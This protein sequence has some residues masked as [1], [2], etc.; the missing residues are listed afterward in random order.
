MSVKT[1]TGPPAP[2]VLAIVC[3]GV[4][5]TALD[6][7]VVVTALP[8]VMVDIKVPISEI[9]QAS[10]IVTG[11][12]VGYTIAMPLVGRISDVY[13]H[14]RVYQ[15]AL[16]L[17]SV[18]SLLVAVADD[19]PWMIS[20][21]VIQAI[22]GGATVPISMAIASMAMPPGRRGLA[23]GLVG[24]SAEAGAMLG[25]LYGGGIIE[26]LEWRWI[27]WLDI[28]QSAVLIA[29]FGLLYNKR[30]PGARVDYLGGALL[31]G[32]L[33]VLTVAL[34]RREM[35]ALEEAASSGL[36][37]LLVAVGL[38]AVVVLVLVEMRAW[39]PLL[40]PALFRSAS[41]VTSNA[42]QL[43]V[44]VALIMA[45][46]NVPLMANTVMGKDALDG[47]LQLMRLT[48]AIPVGAVVGGYVL[49]R[50]GIRRVTVAGLVLMA[51]G[52]YFM[53]TWEA[54]VGEPWL[55]LHLVT[56]GLGFGLVIAPI[57]TTAMSA[58][59]PDYWATAASLVTVSRMVGMALGLAALSAW[60]TDHFLGLT[61][62]LEVPIGLP[63]ES[64]A[65]LAAR[66]AEY[67]QG[68]T[69]AG[70]TLF[71]DFFRVSA[72]ISVVAIL[73]ALG[74]KLA[75]RRLRDMASADDP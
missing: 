6:Q 61:A 68:L 26:L 75:P 27:F 50:A 3:L 55:T 16:V 14:P 64:G 72:A 48:A 32:A 47:G 22:G 66:Q 1:P 35:F 20:A 62:S 43:L 34:S 25:P 49:A 9:D 39:Q 59:H 8:T 29:L 19:L 51:L 28:P 15:A 7:T 65:E 11:Y 52:F 31:A 33:T 57:M 53:S 54:T 67:S 30:T 18:G 23:L 73:P 13:G 24:A 41:F 37:Y 70:V 10:W 38:V 56:G 69:Q 40:A 71:R 58:V 46:V 42:T 60:G 4:F 21:R 2:L 12:L 74:M 17:F 5:S 45:L 36:A 63:G 44:G